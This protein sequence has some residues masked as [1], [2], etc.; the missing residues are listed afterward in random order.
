MKELDPFDASILSVLARVPSD[1]NDL[2]QQLVERIQNEEGK[3]VARAILADDLNATEV[4]TNAKTTAAFFK[5]A[6]AVP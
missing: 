4:S 1:R 5:K 6:F 2:R 3:E